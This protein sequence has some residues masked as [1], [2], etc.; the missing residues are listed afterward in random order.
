MGVGEGVDTSFVSQ[1]RSFLRVIPRPFSFLDN[2]W[3]NIGI[4]RIFKRVTT[5]VIKSLVTELVDCKVYI[6]G[7]SVT[8]VMG[9]WET[10]CTW[11]AKGAPHWLAIVPSGGGMGG[12]IPYQP[13]H[14][15]TAFNVHQ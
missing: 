12:T 15:Y 10:R 8:F 9:Q 14:D 7:C 11:R 6:Y 4:I 13:Y 3:G 5:I 1:V 2:Y